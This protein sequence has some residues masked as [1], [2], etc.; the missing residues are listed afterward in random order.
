MGGV[1]DNEEGGAAGLKVVVVVVVP[2]ILA[3][4]LGIAENRGGAHLLPPL[5][6]W[7]E[8]QKR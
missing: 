2:F 5:K 4:Q 8:L 7:Q 3:R 6:G 1:D